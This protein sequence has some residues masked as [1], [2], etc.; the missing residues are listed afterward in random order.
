M[1]LRDKKQYS[2]AASSATAKKTGSALIISLWTIALLSLLVMSFAL[3]AMLEGKLNL[4]VRERR[5][6]DYMTQSGIAIAEMLL[7]NYKNASSSSESEEESDQWLEYKLNLQRG[8]TTVSKYAI[9]QDHPEN[10]TVTVEITSA[11]A[12]KWPINMLTSS[13]GSDQ[14]WE[15]VLNVIGVPM[16]YQEEIVDSWYDWRD[17]DSTVT[18][19]NGAEQEYYQ[20]LDMPIKPRN[21]EISSID[22]LKMIRCIRDYPAIFSGG[23]LINDDE[24]KKKNT[25]ATR[26]YSKRRNVRR[27]SGRSSSSQ[28]ATTSSRSSGSYGRSDSARNNPN[29]DIDPNEVIIKYGLKSFFDLYG[30]NLKVNVNSASKEVLMTVP[31]IDGDEEIAGAI[32]EERTTGA[33]MMSAVSGDSYESPLFKDWNDLNTRIPGGLET[34]C[35]GYFSYEPQKYFEIK[36][37]GESAGITHTILAVAIVQ[38]DEV[39]YVKWREDP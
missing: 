26:S 38:Q 35:E 6:V 9:E 25:S 2:L 4:Y 30:D 21:G 22:E 3:D 10:G 17:E 20:E 32:I 31:G 14:I 11:E 8:S 29:R 13:D 27:G 1:V 39:R 23:K 33:N 12:N 19:S 18:G 28:T 37:T 15:N 24:K 5:R 16:E 34:E 36:I 7:L